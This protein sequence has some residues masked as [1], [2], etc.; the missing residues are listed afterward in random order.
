MYFS[1]I[2][3]DR[4]LKTH[5]Q[6][7]VGDQIVNPKHDQHTTYR[8]TKEWLMNHVRTLPASFYIKRKCISGDSGNIYALDTAGRKHVL[9]FVGSNY[10]SIHRFVFDTDIP[11]G[12]TTKE[13]ASSEGYSYTSVKSVRQDSPAD[14]HGMSP[15]DIF[16]GRKQKDGS[17]LISQMSESVAAKI[18]SN[19]P[20]FEV[21]R[22]DNISDALRQ[23]QSKSNHESFYGDEEKTGRDNQLPKEFVQSAGI[24]Q[25]EEPIDNSKDKGDAVRD[26]GRLG[27]NADDVIDL[28]SDS[29]ESSEI[30]HAISGVQDQNMT[31]TQLY[32]IGTELWKSFYDESINKRRPFR[33][34]IESYDD[35]NEF[36]KILYEDG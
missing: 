1:S 13:V 8:Q 19:T 26:K 21:I 25:E 27:T 10:A 29:D 17:R 32:S 28:A 11:I 31:K 35:E 7:A 3:F 12:I 15:G 9:S 34:I 22:I 24:L 18:K 4:F 14:K 5:S 20:Q 33:G 6:C 16:I 2:H 23:T 36:Y 30:E